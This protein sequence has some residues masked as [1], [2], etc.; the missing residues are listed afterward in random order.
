MSLSLEDLKVRLQMI[1]ALP[2]FITKK[3]KSVFQKRSL[4]WIF[5]L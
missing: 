4:I 1:G 5:G 2:Y 3:S